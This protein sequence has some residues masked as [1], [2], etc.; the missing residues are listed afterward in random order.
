MVTQFQVAAEHPRPQSNLLQN[1]SISLTSSDYKS[2]IKELM[3]R[4]FDAWVGV[5]EISYYVIDHQHRRL[6]AFRQS[7]GGY[8]EYSL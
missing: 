6:H 1:W 3:Q 8:Y 4:L 2:D 5:E 7:T